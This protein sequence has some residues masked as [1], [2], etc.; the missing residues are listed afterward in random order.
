MMDRLV[1]YAYDIALIS[2][3][4]DDLQKQ[5]DD[6]HKWCADWRMRINVKQITQFVHYRENNTPATNFNFHIGR[7]LES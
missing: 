5:L 1:V 2:E 3:T 4:P 7:Q 6:L